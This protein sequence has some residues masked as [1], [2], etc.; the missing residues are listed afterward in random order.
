MF[1][2]TVNTHPAKKL[3]QSSVLILSHLH[4]IAYRFGRRRNRQDLGQNKS[5]HNLTVK[6]DSFWEITKSEHLKVKKKKRFCGTGIKGGE[7]HWNTF[8]HCL[9]QLLQ[10]GN[11][12]LEAF[13]K[14]IRRDLFSTNEINVKLKSLGTRS[15]SH[16]P[17]PRK[18]N[19]NVHK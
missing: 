11:L 17:S 19:K 13:I 15:A 5:S 8:I 1:T 6:L 2:F 9:K 3:Q 12:A 10:A 4:F 14:S 16:F 7:G 18:Q